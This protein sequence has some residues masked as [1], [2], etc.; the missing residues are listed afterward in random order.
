M[1][2]NISDSFNSSPLRHDTY[3]PKST[4]IYV[5]GLV[6]CL[7]TLGWLGKIYLR[8]WNESTLEMIGRNLLQVPSIRRKFEKEVGEV[9]RKE[10]SHVQHEWK[11]IKCLISAALQRDVDDEVFKFRDQGYSVDEILKIFDVINR[12][13]LK[14]IASKQF[15]GAIY[16]NELKDQ[17]I[18]YPKRVENQSDLAYL[19][20]VINSQTYLWNT[21][22]KEFSPVRFLQ[23]WEKEMVASMFG[24]DPHSTIGFDTTGG[25]G[26]LMQAVR[27]YRE[28]GREERGIGPGKGVMIAPKS[29][30]A[31]E[32]KGGKA[33]D[34]NFI[35]IDCDSTGAV[36]M[37]KMREA[38]KKHK[39][40][41]LAVFASAPCYGTGTVDPIK[42]IIDCANIYNVP[43]H[44]DACL[45]G[46]VRGTN[47][48]KEGA[49]SVSVDPHKYGEAPKGSSVLLV[50]N[51]LAKYSV[52]A[53]PNWTCVYGTP[54]DEGSQSC[55]NQI[56]AFAALLYYGKEG[57]LKTSDRIEEAKNRLAALLKVVEGIE[58]VGRPDVNVVAFKYNIADGA[59]YALVHELSLRN[60]ELNALKDN[61]A[62]ICLTKRILDTPHSL[63]HFI[64]A[65]KESMLAVKQ[66]ADRGEKF[67]GD[68]G[69]YC[70]MGE[71]LMPDVKNLPFKKYVEN[72][73]LGK[74]GAEES[75]KA[76]I[77]AQLNPYAS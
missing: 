74:K 2:K 21:L 18:V 7:V 75:V 37:E 54:K 36:D 39:E 29:I 15:S 46:F 30:H 26:S 71:A 52:Y 19:F 33:Y 17:K 34:V 12:M 61:T 41:L 72:M 77:V 67:P 68:A 3:A 1:I 40:V 66:L 20:M 25:T 24:A 28:K 57:Y 73:L 35:L 47:F 38:I 14:N 55:A 5:A 8:R 42:E 63:E 65:L 10:A 60:W 76:H 59:T 31:A 45:R 50:R 16:P 70:S 62:H 49:T 4:L 23:Y 27:M 9:G 53:L 43:V 48:F 13:V 58:V 11:E 32:L 51:G 56:C 64:M 44:V 69:L 22:H 6:S